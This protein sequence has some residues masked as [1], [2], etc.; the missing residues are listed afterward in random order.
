MTVGQAWA[1]ER[2]QLLPLPARD[3]DCAVNKAVGLNPYSQVEFETNRYSVPVEKAYRNLVLR[4]YPFRVEIIH[5]DQ[6]IASHARCYDREQDI[7]DPLH[8][9]PLLEQRPGAFV[10][11]QP[12]RRWRQAWPPVYERLLA[13]LQAQERNG[14][15]I[16][17]FIRVLKLHQ[18][19]APQLVL[20]AV[21][22]ALAYGCLHAD[23]VE[24]CLRQLL[25]PDTPVPPLTLL[26]PPAWAGVGAQLPD[27]TRYDQLLA[28]G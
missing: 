21:E 3:F 25:Q 6:V 5:L 4:A 28:G 15:G 7:L 27:L 11:A 12:I 23:G 22:Q 10:H 19:Y 26:E 18:T 14:R 2:G 1:Q 9:L 20:Q 16:R 24:L 8:Y 17:E 13:R